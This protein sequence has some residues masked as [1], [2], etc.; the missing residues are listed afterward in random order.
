MKPHYETPPHLTISITDTCNL[1][2]RWCYGD[3]GSKPPS[4]Q[5]TTREWLGFIDYLVA[6]N[7]VQV[8]FEGGEPFHRPDFMEILA[9][10]TP[11]LMTFVRTNGTLVDAALA[12][13][14][15]SIGTGR[16]LVDIMG[17]NPATHDALTGV[18][19]SHRAACDAVRELAGCGIKTDVLVILNRKNAHELQ[20]LAQLAH[21]LGALRLGILRLYPLGRAKRAWEELSLSLREQEEAVAS[22]SPPPGLKVMQS[23]HPRDRNCCWQ[24]AAVNATGDSIGCMYLREYVSFGNIRETTLLDTW[25]DHPLYRQLRSG[26][27]EDSCN[28]CHGND[29]THGGCR[30]TAYAF[31]GSWT[32]PDPF[33]STLN[34]GVDLRVLPRRLLPRPA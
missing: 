26:A 20:D 34:D 22:V 2:C 5:L 15:K 30:S 9:Y 14:L 31:R 25:R 29:G 28:D 8:Y 27:V 17:A 13:R 16:M 19:G 33:C 10:A 4:S 32:A 6:N 12:A 7:F 11:K 21:A 18:T 3:C 24:A 23:W 1:D